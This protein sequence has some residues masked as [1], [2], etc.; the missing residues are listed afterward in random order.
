MRLHHLPSLPPLLY[1]I[2]SVRNADK[3]GLL[4]SADRLQSES[5]E[6]DEEDDDG[7]TPAAS[8]PSAPTSL[9]PSIARAD[10][11]TDGRGR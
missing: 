5:E 10:G 3:A 9:P 1:P 11:W 6:D 2:L 8:C 4:R 7:A